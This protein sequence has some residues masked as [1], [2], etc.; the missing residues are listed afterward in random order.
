MYGAEKAWLKCQIPARKNMLKSEFAHL[1]RLFDKEVQLS[2]RTYWV[3]LQ[4]DIMNDCNHNQS[5][6]WK[7]IGKIG[8]SQEKKSS[9]PLE[10]N[11]NSGISDKIQDVLEK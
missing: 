7:T 3:R 2:K 9:N 10:V 4:Q 8:I 1:R 11:T 5:E 6:F